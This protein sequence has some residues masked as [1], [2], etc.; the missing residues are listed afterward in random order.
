[1]TTPKVDV[2]GKFGATYSQLGRDF[3]AHAHRI[4]VNG[5]GGL[6][7]AAGNAAR[8][9]RNEKNE[10]TPD[11]RIYKIDTEKEIDTVLAKIGSDNRLNPEGFDTA[12]EDKLNELLDKVPEKHQQWFME[13]YSQRRNGYFHTV[14]VNTEENKY[15]RQ[16]EGFMQH[17]EEL[18]AQAMNYAKQ[19]NQAGYNET[20]N[21]W[22][23]NEE[24][25]YSHGFMNI[26]TKI[27]RL[28]DFTN[29]AIVEQQTGYAKQ[30]FG[31]SDKLQS[32]IKSIENSSKYTPEQK[33]SI[34]NSIKGEYSSW[35]AKNKVGNDELSAQA[36]F[37][38]KAYND[39]IEPKDFNAEE[40][41]QNLLSKGLVK[42]AAE[43]QNAVRNKEVTAT[44]AGLNPLQMES[45]LRDM[46]KNAKTKE[47]L[48][49]IKTLESLKDKAENQLANDPLAFALDHNVVDGGA[50]DFNKPES[51][52]SRVQTARVVQQKYGLSY[53]P[54]LTKAE[55]KTL[56]NTLER[57]NAPERAAIVSTLAENFGEEASSVFADIAPKNPEVAVAGKIYTDRPDVAISIIEGKEIKNKESGYAPTKNIDLYNAFGKL[58]SALSNFDTEDVANIKEAIIAQATYLNKKNDIYA[59][60]NAST[61]SNIDEDTI[62]QAITDVLGAEIVSMDKGLHWW[63]D[64]YNTVLPENTSKANFEDWIK[65]LKD[66]DIGKAYVGDNDLNAKKIREECEFR[67]NSRNTYMIFYNGQPVTNEAGEP[68]ILQYGGK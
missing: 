50:I 12:A 8:F 45:T 38:I 53:T 22:R 51:V 57:A 64:N 21:K 19:G 55:T 37:G 15:N 9:Y 56:S 58:D 62:N 11:D 1:M 41:M 67:Y 46:K 23:E 44:F 59:E 40:T 26:H 2:T 52:A 49:L 13:T 43:L 35:Q 63:G 61:K 60:G 65:G 34:I 39:G 29:N 32:Q 5:L 48:S 7:E 4:G 6:I 27:S 18:R 36:D 20:L 66:S 33:K 17:S 28:Q 54:L 30:L 24:Y 47:D 68:I 14:N 42:K 10:D 3:E 16:L 31:N 25:M